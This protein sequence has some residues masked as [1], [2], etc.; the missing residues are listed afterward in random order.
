[1][2]AGRLRAKHS[3]CQRAR[4]SRKAHF[5]LYHYLKFPSRP[6]TTSLEPRKSD[7]LV[8]RG[9]KICQL[10]SPD[11][12]K[13]AVRILQKVALKPLRAWRRSLEV[14]SAHVGRP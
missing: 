2:W 10:G 6:C 11:P 5:N 12:Q 1:M 8:R 7:A 9:R 14:T 3:P 4:A 13:A